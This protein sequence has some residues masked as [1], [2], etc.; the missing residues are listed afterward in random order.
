MQLLVRPLKD[1]AGKTYTI[2]IL[3]ALEAEAE[4][5][6]HQIVNKNNLVSLVTLLVIK[7]L[8]GCYRY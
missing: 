7:I 6:S 5:Y 3:A 4:A 1:S 8:F 2:L